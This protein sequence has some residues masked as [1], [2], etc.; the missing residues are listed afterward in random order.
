MKYS[1]EEGE[2]YTHE[3]FH[4]H[5]KLFCQNGGEKEIQFPI[6]TKSVITTDNGELIFNCQIWLLVLY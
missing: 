1:M 5:G 6:S 4:V 3:G 2:D